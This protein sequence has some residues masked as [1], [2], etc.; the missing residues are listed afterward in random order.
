MCIQDDARAGTWTALV[1][2]NPHDKKKVSAML[3]SPWLDVLAAVGPLPT[4]PH[5]NGAY[6]K[7]KSRDATR[8]TTRFDE[9]KKM[10]LVWGGNSWREWRST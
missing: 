7:I 10:N 6:S 1:S 5:E 4:R 3:R 9:W 8:R 2:C